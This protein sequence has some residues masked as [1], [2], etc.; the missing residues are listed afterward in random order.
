MGIGEQRPHLRGRGLSPR[1]V[2]TWYQALSTVEERGGGPGRSMSRRMTH[3]E[4][5]R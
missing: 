4:Q 3:A 2:V 5:L 1:V